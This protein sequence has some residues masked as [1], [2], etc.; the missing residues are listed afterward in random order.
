MQSIAERG[1]HALRE[2][3]ST[4]ASFQKYDARSKGMVA[5]DPPMTIVQTLKQR[6]GKRLRFPILA[7]VINAPTMRADGV[8]PHRARL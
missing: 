2:D 7:G 4:A 5:A 3:L 1:D 6:E 8:N